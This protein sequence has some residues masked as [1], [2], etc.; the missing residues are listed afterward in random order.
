MHYLKIYFTIYIF[1]VVFFSSIS[2]RLK[3]EAKPQKPIDKKKGRTPRPPPDKRPD[4][5]PPS[6]ANNQIK[7]KEKNK[8]KAGLQCYKWTNMQCVPGRDKSKPECKNGSKGLGAT[9]GF[10][11]ILL[12]VVK[13]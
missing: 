4:K 7:C 10:I 13:L 9:T 12:F 2:G 6:A 3:R 8:G 5:N 11:L 1:V